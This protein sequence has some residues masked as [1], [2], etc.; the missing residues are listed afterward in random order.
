MPDQEENGII[1]QIEKQEHLVIKG[2]TEGGEVVNMESIIVDQVLLQVKQ[3]LPVAAQVN[4][5][6]KQSVPL[7]N[8]NLPEPPLFGSSKEIDLE[9]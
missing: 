5:K 8:L 6:E 4:L 7:A 9:K 3:E 2:E 1:Q